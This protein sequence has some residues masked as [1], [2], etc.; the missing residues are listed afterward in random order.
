MTQEQKYVWLIKT[1]YDAKEISLEDISLKW[2]DDN[3]YGP[4]YKLPRATFYRWKNAIWEQHGIYIVGSQSTKKFSIDNPEV[5]EKGSVIK[6][7]LDTLATGTLINENLD[8]SN[9]ILVSHIPSG[10]DYLKPIIEAMKENRKIE[11]EYRQF[12][13]DYSSTFPIEPYCVKLFE[14]RWYVLGKNNFGKIRVYCLDR[15]KDLN[16]LDETFKLPKDFDAAF[17]SHYGVVIGN[18]IKR[19]HIVLRVFGVQKDYI[20]SL[21]LHESQELIAETEKYADF[22]LYIAPTFDFQQKLLSFGSSVEVIKP[23]ELR[24]EM[25]NW[26]AEMAKLYN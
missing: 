25:K 10:N 1:I 5:I 20:E 17:E 6:W 21:P 26:I 9:R 4:D 12:G 11:I 3:G 7:M 8:M 19:R 22:S 2:R 15:I 14:G 23:I 24:N 16:T 18:D 13:N